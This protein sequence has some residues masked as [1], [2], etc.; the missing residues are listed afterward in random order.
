MPYLFISEVTYL[1]LI[2]MLCLLVCYWKSGCCENCFSVVVIKYFYRQK[3]I[4]I[5]T[6]YIL[7][8]IEENKLTK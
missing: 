8:L 3:K 1:V 2:W 4:K 5:D 6:S 7:R